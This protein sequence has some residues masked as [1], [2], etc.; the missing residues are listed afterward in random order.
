MYL[1][2]TLENKFKLIDER[3]NTLQCT[4]TH[5]HSELVSFTDATFNSRYQTDKINGRRSELLARADLSF[6]ECF[7][8][9]SAPTQSQIKTIYLS[10][11]KFS[12]LNSS[13]DYAINLMNLVKLS[14][15]N[16]LSLYWKL[17][18]SHL[19]NSRSLILR[20]EQVIND[21][22]QVIVLDRVVKKHLI[23][24]TVRNE[25]RVAM[26]NV[27]SCLRRISFRD[28]YAD[29]QK[30]QV[31]LF[32]ESS[33]VC[34]YFV[35]V[36]A[37]V[38]LYLLDYDL[39]IINQLDVFEESFCD[40]KW[41]NQCER[42]FFHQNSSPFY[43]PDSVVLKVKKYQSKLNSVNYPVTKAVVHF[44]LIEPGFSAFKPI[45]FNLDRFEDSAFLSLFND[46]KIILKTYWIRRIHLFK[47][48]DEYNQA[49]HGINKNLFLKSI[50]FKNANLQEFYHV[51]SES[52]IY[53]LASG[54]S[55][56]IRLQNM[57]SMLP[58]SRN[59]FDDDS[60]GERLFDQLYCFNSD[61]CFKFKRRL[62]VFD[63]AFFVSVNRDSFY[64][65][66][67]NTVQVL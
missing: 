54:Y 42:T 7:Q 17:F 28:K 3:L 55:F 2:K 23:V 62:E 6:T 25:L 14:Y 33:I 16:E 8:Q 26:S 38:H 50:Q 22:L 21:K 65:N 63:H 45:D 67:N 43:P 59:A 61:G 12:S 47:A 34:S 32:G 9:T 19:Y 10:T 39:K 35:P 58:D 27:G 31:F 60:G 51:D 20:T 41:M 37:H 36:N 11:T 24:D 29:R 53:A 13:V 18:Y 5:N 1:L 57:A 15:A 52:N 56:S 40:V 64:F 66:I 46:N 30:M 48:S 44:Y 4:I 49:F